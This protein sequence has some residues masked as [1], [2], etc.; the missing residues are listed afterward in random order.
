MTRATIRL[1]AALGLAMAL[2]GCSALDRLGGIGSMPK[3]SEIE[4]PQSLPGY[5]PVSLPM[6]PPLVS[7]RQPG[8]QWRSGSRAF[9]KDL[10]ATRVGDILTVIIDMNDQG[11]L[12]N[13]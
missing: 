4:N 10:R 3:L 12:T 6:P 5:R 7:E 8:S 11:Q 13:G 1:G 2:A 9:F